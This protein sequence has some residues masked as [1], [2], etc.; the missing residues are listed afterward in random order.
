MSS[1]NVLVL[2]KKNRGSIDMLF[3]YNRQKCPSKKGNQPTCRAQVA[4][5]L[6]TSNDCWPTCRHRQTGEAARKG[7]KFGSRDTVDGINPVPS[8]L[9]KRCKSWDNS[10][11]T[12]WW[13]GF[14]NHQQQQWGPDVC[15]DGGGSASSWCWRDSVNILVYPNDI[16]VEFVFFFMDVKPL[17]T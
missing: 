3:K 7:T 15:L 2:Q 4:D 17:W 13:A 8:G 6:P 14:L 10:T 12:N 9:K 5:Y 1:R 11:N 16:D